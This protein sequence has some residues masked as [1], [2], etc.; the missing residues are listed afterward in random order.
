MKLT[1]T[2]IKQII[3]EEI[4]AVMKEVESENSIMEVDAEA[5]KEELINA[6]SEPMTTTNESRRQRR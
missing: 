5:A 4:E 2:E 3:K 6:M 1:K